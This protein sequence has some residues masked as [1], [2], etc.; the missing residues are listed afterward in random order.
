[1]KN[2]LLFLEK[3]KE[4]NHKEWFDANRS[5]YEASKQNLDNFLSLWI[6]K[7]AV[8]DPRV[9]YLK[10]KDCIFRINRDVRFSRD[11]SP[12][13]TH[14]GS[15]LASGGK[16]SEKPCYYLHLE[17]NNCFLAG[18][19]W[20]PAPEKL[21]KIREEIEYNGENLLKIIESD[22]FKSHFSLDEAES[23]K[24]VPKGFDKQSP[25][26]EW[27]KLKSFTVTHPIKDDEIWADDFAEKLSQKCQIMQPFLQFLDLA[28]ED[29]S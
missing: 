6:E 14:F 13:K 3:L 18:G 21:K 5:E 28:F 19:S 16:K 1:M 26:S 4:N 2:I 23:L 12:Y 11:K 8:F 10:P 7:V 22:S 24:T 27:L 25:Y 29:Y 20:M 17:P 9:G 15:V